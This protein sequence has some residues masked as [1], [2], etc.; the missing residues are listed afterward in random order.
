M[1]KVEPSGIPSASLRV[2]PASSG[3]EPARPGPGRGGRGCEGAILQ[4]HVRQLVKRPGR[5][6]N[7]LDLAPRFVR[8]LELLD[9]LV[10]HGHLS[11]NVRVLGIALGRI[12]KTEEGAGRIAT[13]AQVPWLASRAVPRWKAPR[14]WVTI[15]Q[16]PGRRWFLR[17]ERQWPGDLS[18]RSG[19][20]GRNRHLW[21]GRRVFGPG[22]VNV[23]N[24]GARQ[25]APRRRS[26]RRRAQSGES[27]PAGVGREIGRFHRVRQLCP[28]N[29]TPQSCQIGSSFPSCSCSC[30]CSDARGRIDHEQ[31]HE[32]DYEDSTGKYRPG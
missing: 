30:S 1:P 27:Y 13:L 18:R 12:L 11:E 24:G 15:G 10:N 21:M 2:V 6:T 22:P 3:E 17:P 8:S 29:P 7:F 16:W 23:V 32:H 19:R 20:G 4:F 28:V 5:R 26:P 14:R 31:E 9:R 25:S